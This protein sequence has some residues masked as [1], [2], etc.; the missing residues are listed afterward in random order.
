M[1]SHIKTVLAVVIPDRWRPKHSETSPTAEASTHSDND[2]GADRLGPVH[3]H[4]DPGSSS[5]SYG[6][7]RTS[8]SSCSPTRLRHDSSLISVPEE[9]GVAPVPAEGD[10]EP[11]DEDDEEEEVEWELEQMGLYRGEH[12]NL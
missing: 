10:D 2:T 4:L 1:A 8:S 11:V 9:E 12:L 5:Q 7:A 6:H 3:S